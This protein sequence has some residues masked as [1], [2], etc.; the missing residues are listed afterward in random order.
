MRPPQP[1]PDGSVERIEQALR[2]AQSKAEFQRVQCMWLRAALGLNANQVAQ[3]LGWR[4]TS[5]RRLQAQFLRQGEG[6]WECPE[7]GGRRHQNLTRE[8]EARLLESFLPPAKQ[9]GLL[10][11]SRVKLA[12]EQAVGHVVPKSTVY[13][14]LARHGWR[15]LAPR[16][17]HPQAVEARQQAFKKNFPPRLRPAKEQGGPCA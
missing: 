4:P 15:K 7:R 2:G 13:R 8:E 10:E 3:A 6:F 1:F 16:P 11:V 14:M 9:G 17:R 12:Y 5:V